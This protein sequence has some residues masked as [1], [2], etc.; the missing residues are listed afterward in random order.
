VEVAPALPGHPDVQQEAPRPIEP[1]RLQEIP[2]RCECLNAEAGGSKQ[3]LQAAAD[4][5]VVVHDEHGSSALDHADDSQASG[6]V[7]WK[8]APRTELFVAQTS[9]PWASMIDRAMASPMPIPAG[10]VV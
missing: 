9:P 2:G 5:Q 7:N 4:G 1:S 3:A 8:L 6:R 10:F